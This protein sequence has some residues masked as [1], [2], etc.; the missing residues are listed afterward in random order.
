M[1]P[2]GRRKSAAEASSPEGVVTNVT[3]LVSPRARTACSRVEWSSPSSS[4]STVRSSTRD[5]RARIVRSCACKSAAVPTFARD[6]SEGAI[7]V[8]P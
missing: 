8:W 7:F 6:G 5:M 2:L 3:P 1:S 4:R